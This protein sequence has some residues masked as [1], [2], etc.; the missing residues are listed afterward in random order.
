[1]SHLLFADE[2]FFF[3]QATMEDCE[4]IIDILQQYKRESGQKVNLQKSVMCFCRNVK[5]PQ[6]DS[7]SL[8]GVSRVEHHDVYLRL[9]LI[10]GR[11]TGAHFN[12]IKERLWKRLQSGKDKLLS[13][14]RKEILIKALLCKHVYVDLGCLFC[15]A[16]LETAFHM[17][18]DCPF[19]ITTWVASHLVVEDTKFMLSS[20]N[21]DGFAHTHHNANSIAD[22]I[23]RF[24]LNIGT[25]LTW[26]E[27][28]H[29]L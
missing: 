21:G 18:R 29:I 6:Q 5:R 16:H 7:F 9:S 1:M 20:I 8:L 17:L 25:L 12:S 22:H 23:T 11:R 3:A 24:A 2:S 13:G 28:P 14:A 27:E 15:V 19:E 10:V 26:F 4:K